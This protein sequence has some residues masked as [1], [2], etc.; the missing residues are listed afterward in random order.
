MF[1]GVPGVEETP[2]LPLRRLIPFLYAVVIAQFGGIDFFH[3]K[4]ISFYFP[5]NGPHFRF[6]FLIG[7]Y[8]EQ[9]RRKLT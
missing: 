9:L 8:H 4:I 3:Y 2:D 5:H 7:H 1:G 6:F